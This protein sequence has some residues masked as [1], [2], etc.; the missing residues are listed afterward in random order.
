MRTEGQPS[1]DELGLRLAVDGAGAIA[2]TVDAE[3]HRRLN[4]RK[5]VNYASYAHLGRAT[6]PYCPHTGARQQ[7]G[8]CL[9]DVREV[10][11]NTIAGTDISAEKAARVRATRSASSAHVRSRSGRT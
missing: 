5:P 6:G 9:R 2:V 3:Q 4:L 10:T 1:A 11:G 8:Q 7:G